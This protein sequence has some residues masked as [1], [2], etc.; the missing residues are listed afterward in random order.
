MQRFAAS[1]A[2]QR[3]LAVKEWNDR[4]QAPARV[5]LMDGDLHRLSV[6]RHVAFVGRV[7]RRAGGKVAAIARPIDAR[8]HSADLAEQI[9][10]VAIAARRLSHHRDLAGE[11]VG[12]TQP[13]D[14]AHIGASE[15]IQD[16]AVALLAG[17]RQRIAF[18][19]D[20][21]AASAAKDRACD[22]VHD[23]L[24]LGIPL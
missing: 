2:F 24:P 20:S 16:L 19:V 18:D 4:A 17:R 14:L 23:G 1:I 10:D 21:L 3:R 9:I 11:L 13:V 6:E 12:A 8:D 5:H 22:P 7:K 15:K